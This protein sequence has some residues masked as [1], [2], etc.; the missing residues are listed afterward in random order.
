MNKCKDPLGELDILRYRM[1]C[2]I[3]LVGAVQECMVHGDETADS[4][5]NALYGT[6]NYLRS[7]NTEMQEAVDAAFSERQA[8]QREVTHRIPVKEGD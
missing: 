7:L 2:A 4:Y 1:S 8:P 6:F 5:A 3:D